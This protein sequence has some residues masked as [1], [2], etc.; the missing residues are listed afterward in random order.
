MDAAAARAHECVPAATTLSLAFFVVSP[1]DQDPCRPCLTKICER[2]YKSP[3]SRGPGGKVQTA[4]RHLQAC[5]DETAYKPSSRCCSYHPC[6][7]PL[8]VN[9][10][11]AQDAVDMC[12]PAHPPVTSVTVRLPLRLPL[13]TCHREAK[14]A[15]PLSLSKGRTA[16]SC[17][18]L[19]GAAR[20]LP[21]HITRA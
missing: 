20:A 5:S 1:P 9:R 14:Q 13:Q 16:V 6:V 11:E 18:T 19:R 12:M 15:A 8:H 4:V 10:A 2:A 21:E 17:A 7:D 3:L